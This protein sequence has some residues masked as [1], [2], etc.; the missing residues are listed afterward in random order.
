MKATIGKNLID[1]AQVVKHFQAAWLQTFPREPAKYF[2]VLSM[3]RK[4]TPR[5]ARSQAKARPVGPAP[6][7]S[8]EVSAVIC[9]SIHL[10][11]CETITVVR[12]SEEQR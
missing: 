2:S 7:M 1:D 11:T 12:Q 3:M 5:R 4:E 6:T 8:T 9:A 10:P